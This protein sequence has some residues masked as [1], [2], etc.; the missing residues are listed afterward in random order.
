MSRVIIF[1]CGG[2]GVEAK[3]ALIS[4]GYEI[5]CFSDNSESKWGTFFEGEKVISPEQILQ[6][7]FD[8]VAIGVFKAADI[9]RKQLHELGINDGRIIVPIEPN[10]IFPARET[11]PKNELM[12]LKQS[13]YTSKN[14]QDYRALNIEIGDKRFLQN[15]N[16]LKKK[17]IENNI[18]REKV[19]VVSGAV[20]QVFGLR[21]SKEFDDI[22]IIM[23]SDLRKLYGTDLV[24]ISNTAEMHIQNQ[25]SISDDEIIYDDKNHFAFSELKFMHPAILYQYGTKIKSGEYT[26][27][28]Q[29]CNLGGF[30]CV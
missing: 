14:T 5:V 29:Y 3:R 21:E 19:C 28:K 17:L 6:E 13:E 27:L 4:E 15:L 9:I 23:T 2:V 18:P 25:Y 12:T 8:F 24:I 11:V 16:L 10:R 20:L 22:D 1:G 30:D 26:S 7:Q